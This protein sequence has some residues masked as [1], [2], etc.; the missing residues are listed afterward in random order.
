MRQCGVEK[1]VMRKASGTYTLKAWE[2]I[3][4]TEEELL[5]FSD[6]LAQL[7][8]RFSTHVDKRIP[9]RMYLVK[10]DSH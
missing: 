1:V 9:T 8:V 4:V 10:P 7:V 3:S 2:K 6:L 5:C